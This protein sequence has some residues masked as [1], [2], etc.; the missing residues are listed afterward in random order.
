MIIMMNINL[1][2]KQKKFEKSALCLKTDPA[3]RQRG[4]PIKTRPQLSNSNKYLV[5]S[6]R[7]GSA[8]RLND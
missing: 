5:M 6:P 8:P 4:R 1:K 3:A 2:T 7:W